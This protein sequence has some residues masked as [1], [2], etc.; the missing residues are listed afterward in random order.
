[1]LKFCPECKKDVNARKEMSWFICSECKLVWNPDNRK[2][3][4]F[5]YDENGNYHLI[6]DKNA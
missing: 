1:M 6:G 4:S 5:R 2:Y 3:H